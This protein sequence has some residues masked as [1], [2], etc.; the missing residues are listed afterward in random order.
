MIGSRGGRCKPRLSLAFAVLV[1]GLAISG[2]ACNREDGSI[3]EE[4]PPAVSDPV[5]DAAIASAVED[6]LETTRHP[7]LRWPSW[8]TWRPLAVSRPES[9]GSLWFEGGRRFRPPRKRSTRSRAE[10]HALRPADYDPSG[11][12]EEWKRISAKAPVQVTERVLFD[13]AVSIGVLREI[14]AVRTG[15]VDPR[16]L[17]WGYDVTPKKLDRAAL[18]LGARDGA[19]VTAL[20]DGLEPSFP[21][22]KRNRKML[23]HYRSLARAGEPEPVPSLP[24]GRRKV[25][26]GEPWEGVSQMR[27]RLRVFGDLEQDSPTAATSDGTPLYDAALVEAVKRFQRRHILDADGVVGSATIEALNVT[28]SARVRQLE[29]AME[30]GRWLPPFG[31]PTVFVNVPIFRLWASDPTRDED[32]LRMSVVVGKSLGHNTPLFVQEM[33]YVIFR[34]YWNPPYSIVTEEILPRARRE[35]SYLE[36]ERFE[37]VASGDDDAKALPATPENLEA[38]EAGRLY[39]RQKPG[40]RNSLGLAKFIFPNRANVYMHGTPAPYLFAR[41]RR[42]F[43]H[44]CIRLENPTGLAEWVLR[45]VPGWTRERIDEAMRAERPTRV[46]LREP[47]RVVI[48]YDTVHVNSENVVHFVG[49]IYGH[50]RTL[51]EALER[52]YPYPEED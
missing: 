18:L 33:E 15:R 3:P 5:A 4:L 21:H 40:P 49:D 2:T 46:N 24:K 20:L 38:V 1:S 12:Q 43:S 34:P 10:E 41:T 8:P 7:W 52:G 42:D 47:L 13:L 32:V 28:L 44:G 22:Y 11:I 35:P 23:V 37:I 6:V 9:D 14:Q 36:A 30:R 50:D 48:F 19:G 45:D 25:E 31:E 39:L 29:L 51:D 27:A 26:P 17:D 16:T